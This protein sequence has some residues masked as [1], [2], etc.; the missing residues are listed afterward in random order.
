[1]LENVSANQWRFPFDSLDRVLAGSS[2]DLFCAS[3]RSARRT[4]AELVLFGVHGDDGLGYTQVFTGR[5]HCYN[6]GAFTYDHNDAN[7]AMINHPNQKIVVADLKGGSDTA[8]RNMPE[9]AKQALAATTTTHPS[10]FPDAVQH[11]SAGFCP[12]SGNWLICGTWCS[13]MA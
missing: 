3:R 1:V 6:L 13:M 10:S 5:A 12:R 4:T 11:S 7:V 2:Y 8:T 9:I